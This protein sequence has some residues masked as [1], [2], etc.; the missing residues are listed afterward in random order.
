[1]PI[2]QPSPPLARLAATLLAAALALWLLLML[3]APA[4]AQVPTAAPVM[5][6][7]VVTPAPAA[8]PGPAAGQPPAGLPG[9]GFDP[10]A[11]LGEQVRK[12]LAELLATVIRPARD[13][14]RDTLDRQFNVLTVTRPEHSIG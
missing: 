12:A 1:M 6:S 9:I 2:Y 7:P 11:L 3:A 5:P 8:P 10:F 13:A 14:V 4:A